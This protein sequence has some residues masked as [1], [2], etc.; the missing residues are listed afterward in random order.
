M[1]AFASMWDDVE[2]IDIAT[3]APVIPDIPERPDYSI[4]T[5]LIYKDADPEGTARMWE[6]LRLE[7]AARHAVE[8]AAAA[9][10]EAGEEESDITITLPAEEFD[11]PIKPLAGVV[12][13]AHKNGWEIVSLAHSMAFEKGKPFKTGARAGQVRPDM[14]HECQWVHLKKPGVG[15]VAVYYSIVND[16]PRGNAVARRFNGNRYSDRELK[17]I[18]KGEHNAH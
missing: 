16:V 6:N 13:L 11:D 5:E 18:I 9:A 12:S 14:T 4:R 10:S 3:P 7:R 2:D 17:A 15:R 1:E 8:D